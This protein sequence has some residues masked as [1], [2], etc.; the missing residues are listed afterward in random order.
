MEQP[1]APSDTDFASRETKITH[2]QPENTCELRENAQ[3]PPVIDHKLVATQ[4]QERKD[5]DAVLLE[6][7]GVLRQIDDQVTSLYLEHVAFPQKACLPMKRPI[8]CSHGGD[9]YPGGDAR[10]KR[11]QGICNFNVLL[12]V[13]LT[14]LWFIF[15][16]VF[17]YITQ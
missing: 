13:K 6:L 5:V 14:T 16:M 17:S 10:A 7:E 12:C 3:P 1:N 9:V 8:T 2:Q 15:C 4:Q 11:A